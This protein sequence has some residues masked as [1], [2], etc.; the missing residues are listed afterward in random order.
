MLT[1]IL[2]KLALGVLTPVAAWVGL[3][4]ANWLGAMSGESKAAAVAARALHFAELVAS[5]LEAT[6]KPQLVKDLEDG[7]LSPEEGA[8]LKAMAME[9]LKLLMGQHGLEEL[10]AVL[11]I[12]APQLD[13]YLSGVIEKAVARVSMARTVTPLPLGKSTLQLRHLAP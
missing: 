11:G 12:V 1:G 3:K 8:K 7:K 2:L 10:R 6:V 9:R 5:D 4:L 13:A